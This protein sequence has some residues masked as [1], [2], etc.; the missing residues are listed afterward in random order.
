MRMN[1]FPKV[2]CDFYLEI[3]DRL[4][5]SF[6]PNEL[7][8]EDILGQLFAITGGEESSL[9]SLT[10]SRIQALF[11]VDQDLVIVKH[12]DARAALIIVQMDFYLDI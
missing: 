12:Q 7:Q 6:N 10:H 8:L 5:E 1:H 2:T 9:I 11:S 3:H 4:A